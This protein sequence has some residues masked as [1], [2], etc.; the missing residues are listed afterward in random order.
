MV[1]NERDPAGAH[2]CG[3]VGLPVLP[4]LG[5]RDHLPRLLP[6]GA[7][8]APPLCSVRFRLRRSTCAGDVPRRHCRRRRRCRRGI[9]RAPVVP[10]GPGGRGRADGAGRRKFREHRRGD[11]P[12]AS[13]P[14]RPA[15]PRGQPQSLSCQRAGA[16]GHR[17]RCQHA[18]VGRGVARRHRP[19]RRLLRGLDLRRLGDLRLG[20]L[21]EQ[22]C[23]EVDGSQ[24]P[25]RH[26]G[27]RPGGQVL[28]RRGQRHGD[29]RA[30]GSDSQQDVAGPGPQ[31][32]RSGLFHPLLR[33]ESAPRS[34]HQ[35]G[36]PGA[37]ARDGREGR[38]APGGHGARTGGC[39]EVPGVDSWQRDRAGGRR[40]S[41]DGVREVPPD[42]LGAYS[43]ARSRQVHLYITEKIL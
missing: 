24:P 12:T 11:R 32:C 14:G 3:Q 34:A 18:G 16:A 1:Q 38:A 28:A 27:E 17:R 39:R 37:R 26:A 9:E 23:R 25:H 19:C 22:L 2:T 10:L 8:S 36:L 33:R 5:I 43:P 42:I 30:V 7:H 31:Q 13:G 4:P 21:G 35:R 41:P 29:H 40:G 15:S 6:G 20:E